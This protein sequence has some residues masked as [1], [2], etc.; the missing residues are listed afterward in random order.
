MRIVITGG[1]NTLLG[2][3]WRPHFEALVPDGTQITNLAI[4]GTTSAM[5]IFRLLTQGRVQPGDVVLWEYA[6]NEHGH[7][8]H[9]HGLGVLMHHVEALIRLVAEAGGHL[10]PIIFTTQAQE[11]R[12]EFDD[13]RARLHFTFATHDVPFFDVSQ[14]FRRQF[15]VARLAKEMFQDNFHYMPNGEIVKGIAESVL[16]RLGSIPMTRFHPDRAML[17][18]PRRTFAAIDTFTGA[19]VSEFRTGIIRTP[20][21]SFDQ[22][23]QTKIRGRLMAAAVIGAPE[24]G[25]FTIRAGDEVLGSYSTRRAYE[26]R[27]PRRIVKQISFHA[28]AGKPLV[29]FNKP[30]VI[31]RAA[32]DETLIAD[33]TYETD[34]VPAEGEAE[35]ALLGLLVD[36]MR[37]RDG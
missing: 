17:A 34:R 8:R 6:L 24:G 9:G 4:G 16:A 19:E 18:D 23:L 22:E 15:G 20:I 21:F 26:E 31:S 35:D 3:G 13:Y 27:G 30:V 10:L 5:G 11:T 28:L 25:G 29:C 7:Y 14:E 1:S 37:D 2:G 33:H 36:R 32:A 12:T